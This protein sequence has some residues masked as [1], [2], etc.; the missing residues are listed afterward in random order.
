MKK[1]RIFLSVFAVALAVTATFAMRLNP[2]MIGFEYIPASGSAPAQC[3]ERTVDC[4][5]EANNECQ[6]NSHDVYR[7]DAQTN[8]GILLKKQ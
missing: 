2:P 6:L 8:C 1:V 4:V 5:I 3:V 7:P